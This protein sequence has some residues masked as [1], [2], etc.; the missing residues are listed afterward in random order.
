VFDACQGLSSSD[1]TQNPSCVFESDSGSSTGDAGLDS[2]NQGH[3]HASPDAPQPHPC[4]QTASASDCQRLVD[5]GVCRMGSRCSNDKCDEC[6]MCYEQIMPAL[7]YSD[8]A[9]PLEKANQ[10]HDFCYALVY[11][12]AEKYTDAVSLNKFLLDAYGR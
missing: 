4:F 11:Q 1:C 12:M 5:Q 6:E 2:L 9:T 3:C 7:T 8:G 10:F